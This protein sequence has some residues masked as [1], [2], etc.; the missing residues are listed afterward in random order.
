[1]KVRSVFIR[2]RNNK[3]VVTL[4]YED[5]TGKH[6]KNLST[7]ASKSEANKAV[8]L[9]KS[10]YL[11]DNLNIS[12]KTV[13]DWAREYINLHMNSYTENT[14][15]AYQSALRVDIE[16]YFREKK[17]NDISVLEVQSFYRYLS[18][19][20]NTNTA[21][22][23]FRSLKVI[24]RRAYQLELIAKDITE[25]VVLDRSTPREE[26]QYYSREQIEKMLH[27]LEE[28]DSPL[29][30]PVALGALAG[31][32]I[33]EVIA[34]KWE[35]IDWT[36]RTISVS[37]QAIFKEGK[38]QLIPCKYNSCGVL[39]IS[40]LLYDIL[41][42]TYDKRSGV[43]QEICLNAL[44][45]PY[46]WNNLSHR[47]KIWTTRHDIP[48]HGFH[49]LRHG[50]LTML[51][52]SNCPVNVIKAYARHR[53]LVVTANYVHASLEDMRLYVQ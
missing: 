51:A 47:F 30:T 33:N 52:S 42:D 21:L 11:K 5:E 15:R 39:P 19:K 37:R 25:H 8:V 2:N 17:L 13:T 36:N 40:K 22:A 3:Y 45:R 28:E 1:M 43:Y 50:F 34:L 16:P 29:L 23:R 6:T 14:R 18:E 9:A 7:H 26:R 4:E 38:R 31:L 49:S 12:D 41:K 27:I 24:L 32:R 10:E 44:G 46:S 53:S 20:Y 35:D 48:Y